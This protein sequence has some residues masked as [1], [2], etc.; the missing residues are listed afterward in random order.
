MTTPVV[1]SFDEFA[2]TRKTAKQIAQEVSDA[3]HRLEG[4]G[5][6]VH[7]PRPPQNITT[8]LDIERL[9]GRKRIKFGI[10]CCSHYGSKFQAKTPLA[11]FAAYAK[12]QKVDYMIHAGDVTDGPFDRHKN[13]HEVFLHDFDRVVE[14]AAKTLPNT[15]IPWLMLGGN[16]DSWFK[17]GGGPDVIEAIARER[18]DV[19]YIGDSLGYVTLEDTRFEVVHPH[20][21][22]AYAYSYRLQ[23]HIES[24]APH[25]K[26]AVCIMGNFHKFAS[27]FYRGVFGVQTPAFQTQTPWMANKSLVSEVGGIILEIGTHPQGIAPSVKFELVYSFTPRLDDW[28]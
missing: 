21:G 19:T 5:Y 6:L 25:L 16:H 3:M 1:P 24:L 10:V 23:K 15:G 20:Q 12:N 13:P 27:V 18:D 9:R 17:L 11:Q 4:Q 2:E 14:Y 7:K 28:P 22:S 26:P 8:E